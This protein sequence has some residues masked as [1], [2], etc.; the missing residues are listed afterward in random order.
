MPDSEFPV[1]SDKELLRRLEEMSDEEMRQ[2]VPMPGAIFEPAAPPA[3]SPEGEP[4][5]DV[6]KLEVREERPGETVGSEGEELLAVA[7]SI[8][9]ILREMHDDMKR[10]FSLD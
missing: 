6:S 1:P 4:Q 10:G 7:K 8:Q 3:E 2:E 9:R 5:R